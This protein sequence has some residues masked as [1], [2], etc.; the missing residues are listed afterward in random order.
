M[1]EEGLTILP[2]AW[3]RTKRAVLK[4][5]AP[6]APTAGSTITPGPLPPPIRALL[7]EMLDGHGAAIALRTRRVTS[8]QLQEVTAL[9]A[10]GATE[11]FGTRPFTLRY[12]GVDS[13]PIPL[14]AS[15]DEFLA[16]LLP[17]AITGLAP[18]DLF[19]YGGITQEEIPDTLPRQPSGNLGAYHW[20]IAFVGPQFDTDDP[21]PIKCLAH[22]DDFSAIMI[23]YQSVWEPYGEPILVYE[24]GLFRGER[25]YIPYQFNRTRYY[26]GTAVLC[27]WM[28]DAEGYVVFSAENKRVEDY[29]QIWEAW[30][31]AHAWVEFVPTADFT[32]DPLEG[33]DTLLQ[34]ID[35][36]FESGW[37]YGNGYGFGFGS[38]R[39]FGSSWAPYVGRRVRVRSDDELPEGLLPE[40]DYYLVSW[41]WNTRRFQL[42]A[43]ERG[44]PRSVTSAGSGLLEIQLYGDLPP[45]PPIP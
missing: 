24:G 27:V 29:A 31:N 11:S 23:A 22:P 21:E 7:Y 4:V 3:E 45:L 5:E 42:S 12:R 36:D 8:H 28:P 44:A 16:A 33:D 26:P 6:G 43:T 18:G 40:T 15:D 9:R 37:G 1:S 35:N 20:T 13:L 14:G 2:C 30:V 34:A 19:V 41:S 10:N 17:W 32:V 38:L 25:E 39:G